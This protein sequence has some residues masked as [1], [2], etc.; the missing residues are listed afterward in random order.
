MS[1]LVVTNTIPTGMAI[2]PA[3][4][5]ISTSPGLTYS[6]TVSPVITPDSDT[7]ITGQTQ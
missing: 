7:I 4:V 5:A 3:S 2:L 6:G 1:S